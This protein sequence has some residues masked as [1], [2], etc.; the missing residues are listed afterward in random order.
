MPKSK[1][2]IAARRQPQQNFRDRKRE[3]ELEAA[4]LRFWTFVRTK[5]PLDSLLGK[6][7]LE[8]WALDDLG[9]KLLKD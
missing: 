4:L 3:L 5:I 8:C 7:Q 9:R 6:D 2:T 1:K